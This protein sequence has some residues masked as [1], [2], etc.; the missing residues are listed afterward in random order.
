MVASPIF[1]FVYLDPLLK[2]LRTKGIGCHIACM[3]MGVVAYANDIVLLA[4]NRN[5][6]RNMLA[7]CEKYAIAN[8]IMFSTDVNPNK[9]KSKALYVVGHKGNSGK[10]APLMLDGK[11]LPWVDKCEH[12]GHTLNVTA[13]MEQ[14]CKIK[15]SKFIEDAV[16][17]REQFKYAHPIEI[18]NATETYCSSHYG[19][20]L[21]SLRG[22][23]SKML[24]ASWRTNIKLVWNLPR[25]TRSYFVDH[26][27]A[28]GVTPPSVSLMTRQLSF[29]HSLLNSVSPE[30]QVLSRIAARD[31]RTT[32][33]SN[34]AHIHTETGLDPW[35]FGGKRVRD[36]LLK[37][38]KSEVSDKDR[39]RL[40]YLDKLLT[41]RLH[42]F[43]NGS[44]S[45]EELDA[46]IHSL[47]IN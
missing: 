46:L 18:I 21:W 43:Y 38:Q 13:T 14:D 22:N 20:N 15:R 44:Q 32:L 5:A 27:L 26:L 37:Y 6:A 19:H 1:W 17:L 42:Q 47:C 30:A 36:D 28:A 31:I 33:G 41:Q 29:F 3:Y 9:S 35:Q 39:W 24:Y 8:N 16:K 10:P 40:K 34:L 25:E 2:E 11:E 23:A 4:P 12:L 45:C 7:T